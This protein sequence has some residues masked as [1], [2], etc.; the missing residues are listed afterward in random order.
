MIKKILDSLKNY[1]GKLYLVLDGAAIESLG[2]KIYSLDQNPSYIPLCF[3]TEF[4]A[5]INVSPLMGYYIR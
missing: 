4:E 5:V 3:D 1:N 2:E